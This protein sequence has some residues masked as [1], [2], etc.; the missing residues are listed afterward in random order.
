M[1]TVSIVVLTVCTVVPFTVVSVV[2][3]EIVTMGVGVIVSKV[4]A[5]SVIVFDG[6]VVKSVVIEAVFMIIVVSGCG[7]QMIEAML[8]SLMVR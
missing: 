8:I 5:V 2:V 4:C 1:V 3:S 7:I 6:Q